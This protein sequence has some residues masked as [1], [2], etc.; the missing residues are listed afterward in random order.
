M[1]VIIVG[2][3]LFGYVDGLT[4]TSGSTEEGVHVVLDV[5]IQEIVESD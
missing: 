2:S 3:K 1:R 5:E 4:S